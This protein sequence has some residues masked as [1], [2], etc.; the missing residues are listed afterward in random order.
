MRL[1]IIVAILC[2][3][4][5]GY[6][7]AEAE[8]ETDARLSQRIT[9]DCT[10]VRLHTAIERIA[11]GTGVSISTGKSGGDWNVRDVPVVVC[12][13]DIPLGVLLRGIADTTHLLFSRTKTDDTWNYRIWRDLKRQ[14]ELDAYEDLRRAAALAATTYDWDMLCKVKDLPKS[15]F[16][17]KH[18]IG[19]TS[20]KGFELM[21]EVTRAAAEIVAGL[22]PDVKDRVLAG[23]MVVVGA[24]NASTSAKQ[25]LTTGAEAFW[26]STEQMAIRDGSKAPAPLSEKAI[27]KTF[28]RLDLGEQYGYPDKLNIEWWQGDSGFCRLGDFDNYATYVRKQNPDLPERPEAPQTPL[29]DSLGPRYVKLPMSYEAYYMRDQP[30]HPEPGTKGAAFLNEKVKIGKDASKQTY[31]DVL[32]TI[33]GGIGF[34]IIA[35]GSAARFATRVMTDDQALAG[36]FGREVTVREALSL[37]TGIARIDWYVDEANKLI[38]GRDREWTERLQA[39]VPEKLILGLSSKAK[40]KGIELD[41]L[42]PLAGLTPKQVSEWIGYCPEYPEVARLGS[43]ATYVGRDDLTK[44]YFSLSRQE[45]ALARSGKPVSLAGCD[46]TRV[47]EVLRKHV[48]DRLF[49]EILAGYPSAGES[50]L[51][52]SIVKGEAFSDPDSLPELWIR[53]ERNNVSK[54]YKVD[55]HTYTIHVEGKDEGA[56]QAAQTLFGFFPIVAPQ[57]KAKPGQ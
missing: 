40:S 36:M 34:S 47:C 45:R 8:V 54:E 56:I 11:A 38:I 15:E 6:C 28:I 2:A 21:A 10:N 29:L 39:L 16:E 25:S 9:A 3:M 1:L 46:P 41:D 35:E 12:A 33:S 48:A 19:T 42:Q 4:A 26:K 24:P 30:Y 18:A 14:S 20:D 50:P 32:S 53:V 49:Q 27:N 7:C 17:E 23:E 43:V 44:L 51:K 37:S 13:K 5:C 55:K 31:A 57:P 52:P 22:G